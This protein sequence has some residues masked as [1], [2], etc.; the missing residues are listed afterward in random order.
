MTLQSQSNKEGTI[1]RKIA[2]KWNRIENAERNPLTYNHVIFDKGVKTYIGKKSYFST[3][4]ST[5]G[6]GKT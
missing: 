4:F 1:R 2:N 6:A 3:T 5:N